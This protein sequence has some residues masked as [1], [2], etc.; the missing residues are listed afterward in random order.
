[1]ASAACRLGRPSD[2]PR[3]RLGFTPPDR[4]VL[5]SPNLALHVGRPG[6]RFPGIPIRH[7]RPPEAKLIPVAQPP[8]PTDALPVKKRSMAGHSLV[9]HRPAIADILELGVQPRHLAVPLERNVCR[10]AAPDRESPARVSQL[11]YQLATPRSAVDEEGSPPL[12]GVDL[13]LPIWV[14]SRF[15]G[16]AV[17]HGWC[18]SDTAD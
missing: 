16:G 17:I 9:D 12:F 5:V 11:D 7:R 10:G 6:A 14:G 18:P 2:P 15:C 8:P 4:R 13:L 3:R 1:M